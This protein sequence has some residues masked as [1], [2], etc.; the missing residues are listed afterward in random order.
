MSDHCNAT[1]GGYEGLA[2]WLND[3][4]IILYIFIV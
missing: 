1:C 2:P 4:I 3:T